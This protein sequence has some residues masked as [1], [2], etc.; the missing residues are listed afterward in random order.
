MIEVSM[1]TDLSLRV[2]VCVCFVFVL[3]L[4]N[5][6]GSFNKSKAYLFPQIVL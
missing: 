4:V 6:T 5:L 2:C 1:V 3:M